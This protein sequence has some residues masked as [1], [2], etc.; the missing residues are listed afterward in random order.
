[1]N[2]AY[3]DNHGANKPLERSQY[4]RHSGSAGVTKAFDG[5]WRAS[6][7]YFGASGDGLAESSFGRLDLT[8]SKSGQVQGWAWAAVFGVRR[9]DN[10]KASFANGD[11]AQLFARFDDRVQGFVQV[12][13]RLP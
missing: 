4:S 12:S 1:M 13:L 6:V 7:A 8:L 11:T 10:P 5:G 2:Y 9:L 3:L